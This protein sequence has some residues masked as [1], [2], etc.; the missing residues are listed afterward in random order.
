MAAWR[1]RAVPVGKPSSP[2]ATLDATRIA[3]G[4]WR[5]G[6]GAM[7]RVAPGDYVIR[8]RL[9]IRA[10]AGWNGEAVSDDIPL[11]VVATSASDARSSQRAVNLAQDALL[12]NRVEEAAATLDA[13]LVRAPDD[14]AVLTARALV[15]ERAGNTLAAV[16]CLNRAQ[17]AMTAAGGGPPPIELPELSTRLA[18]ARLAPSAAAENQPKWSWPPAAVLTL[19]P[20][21]VDP[22]PSAPTAVIPSL[23]RAVPATPSSMSPAASPGQAP[24]PLTPSPP[25]RVPVPVAPATN[26]AA[27]AG[28]PATGVVLP[29]TELS[30]AKIRADAAGQWAA[31]AR[32]GSEY[33]RTQYSAARAT[34][35]PNVPIVGNSPDAW[36]PASKDK[37]S[38]WLE[39]TFAKPVRAIEVRIRQNDAAGAIAKVEAIE[40]DGTAHVWWEGADPLVAPAVR[41]IAWFAVRVPKTDYLVV[42]MKITLNLASGP[43]WKQIDAVQLV[44]ADGQKP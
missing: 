30:D 10:G 27:R 11:R 44:A 25:P 40:P 29:A 26:L 33:G 15:A 4:L 18:A 23:P 39:V 3:G 17:R 36:C 12:D 42:K 20:E 28:T 7:E 9:T 6:S 19:S 14:V 32:A 2:T 38:D 16:L 35:A 37:G 21:T 1:A 22:A 41:D 8:A 31:S 34:G 43:G 5:I 24:A 13:R